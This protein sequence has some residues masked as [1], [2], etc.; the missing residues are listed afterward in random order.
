M[1]YIILIVIIIIITPITQ[2]YLIRR[3]TKPV[4]QIVITVDERGK[5]LFSLE[6]DKNPDEIANM[7]NIVFKVVNLLEDDSE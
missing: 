7:T 1:I 3:R 2:I 4:G 5:K 6:L